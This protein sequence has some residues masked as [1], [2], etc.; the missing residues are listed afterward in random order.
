MERAVA[1]YCALRRGPFAWMVN[2]FIVSAGRMREMIAVL[3][4]G[5]PPLAL[6]V[7]LSAPS[8]LSVLTEHGRD[9]RISVEATELRLEAE[10]IERWAQR[11]SQGAG[12]ALPSY[13]ELAPERADAMPLLARHGLRAKVRCGGAEARMVPA[14]EVLARFIVAAANAGVAYKATA[15]LHHPLRHFNREAAMTMHGFLNVIAASVSA[16]SGASVEEVTDILAR[17]EP[18]DLD[19]LGERAIRQTRELGFI[20]YGSCSVR[21]PVEDLR[22]LGLL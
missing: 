6:S 7:L 17:E 1:E 11:R 16:R 3:P 19:A 10:E 21:E 22:S 12:A 4:A 20:G 5:E 9:P 15:G 14:P 13:V 8:D 2:R 18:I